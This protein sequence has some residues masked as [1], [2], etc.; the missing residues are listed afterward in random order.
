MNRS[1]KKAQ[2]TAV[3]E[4]I[5]LY[6]EICGTTPLLNGQ[7]CAVI[8]R[9]AAWAVAEAAAKSAGPDRSSVLEEAAL[10]AD[11]YAGRCRAKDWE[12]GAGAGE[13]I[14]RYIRALK[15]AAP[16]GSEEIETTASRVAP[17]RAASEQP[18]AGAERA[19]L[20]KLCSSHATPD[21]G[22]KNGN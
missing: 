9:L 16:Q 3:G 19:A 2:P 4:Y 13:D 15:N 12:A 7:E 18:E 5:D 1:T 8:E 20:A 22:G 14:A 11:E 17:A 10:K 6:R 21:L